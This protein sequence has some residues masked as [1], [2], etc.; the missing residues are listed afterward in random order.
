MKQLVYSASQPPLLGRWVLHFVAQ[1]L[2]QQIKNNARWSIFAGC[3][4][5]AQAAADTA[6]FRSRSPPPPPRAEAMM[7]N[8]PLPPARTAFYCSM[9]SLAAPSLLL[10]RGDATTLQ[11]KTETELWF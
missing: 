1:P 7:I 3:R 2:D 5:H 10:Q 8:A 9:Y 6:A 4:K 11:F